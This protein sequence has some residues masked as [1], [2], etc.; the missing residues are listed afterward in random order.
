MKKIKFNFVKHNSH[1]L[2]ALGI[3]LRFVILISFIILLLKRIVFLT[4]PNYFKEPSALINIKL[5]G[6]HMS[7]WHCIR[8][9]SSENK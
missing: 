6:V 3:S 1:E 2:N 4:L 7:L 8:F 9:T 5:H